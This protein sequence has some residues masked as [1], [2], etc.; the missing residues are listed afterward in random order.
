VRIS[1]PGNLL[2]LEIDPNAATAG[3]NALTLP[4]LLTGS[5]AN[6]NTGL[7][8]NNSGEIALTNS[9][10]N[11]PS[12]GGVTVASG[13]IN[14]SG[15]TGG[16]I[17]IIGNKVEVIN[18]N[19]NASG[20]N[21]GGTVL[22]G[23]DYQGKGTIPNA[24]T[25]FINKKS[26]INADAVTKGDGGK[27]IVWSDQKTQFDGNITAK[28]GSQSGNGGFAE[29]SGKQKLTYTGFTDLR[30]PNGQ[31]G[32][33]LL[34]PDTFTIANTGG[35]IDPATVATQW[36]A[37]DTVYQAT[38]SLTVTDAVTGA[39]GFTL[40][41][42]APTINLNAPITNSGTGQLS[43]TAN[44]VNVG[45][46][47][48]IQNGVDVAATDGKVNLAAATYTLS[49]Q[50]DIDKSLTLTGAGADNTTVSGDNAVRVFN[51]SGTGTDVTIDSLTISN[52]KADNG[53]GIQVEQ[54]SELILLSSNIYDNEAEKGGGIYNEGIVTISDSNIFE[55]FA[56]SGGGIYN[57][58]KATISDSN[59]FE[60]FAISGG[61]IY[62][63]GKATISDSNIFENFAISGGGIYNEGKATISDSNI[64]E[65]S[66]YFDADIYNEGTI[67]IS[68]S[69]IFDN[70]ILEDEDFQDNEDFD[71]EDF[72]DETISVIS[73][74]DTLSVADEQTAIDQ[75][76][77]ISSEEFS[78][79]LELSALHNIGM[80]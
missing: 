36:N 48:S 80:N 25:T 29:V 56:I 19:I 34:D 39:S 68:N 74:D 75:V 73:T 71:D 45:A 57:E 20:T 66:A 18:S 21:G 63:E 5:S 10:T 76:E 28:G 32:T 43:G 77:D 70:Q 55:N 8:V 30:A 52:G 40:T 16:K 14:T 49:Q 78:S 12:N 51:I 4:Q 9:G 11:I 24:Q 2:S 6:T 47:G 26:Q 54:G 23:G 79:F 60:N 31:V 65:N 41:L 42:D 44:T 13:N 1:H 67:I 35:D 53:G 50:V 46:N 72:D 64:F 69:D 38:T 37:A 33:L 27:V 58:G 61:G 22:I 15:Q 17:N 3:I 62:N 7:T 59:I